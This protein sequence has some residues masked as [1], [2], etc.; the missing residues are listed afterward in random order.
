[1]TERTAARHPPPR[2]VQGLSRFHQ[3]QEVPPCSTPHLSPRTY[4]ASLDCDSPCP[5]ADQHSPLNSR[6]THPGKVLLYIPIPDQLVEIGTLMPTKRKLSSPT[7]PK[8]AD[9]FSLRPGLPHLRSGTTVLPGAQKSSLILPSPHHPLP[10]THPSI[11]S[12]KR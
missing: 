4:I 12:L 11:S 1:M 6:L 7:P 8:R 2:A 9:L 5:S 10:T 3:L